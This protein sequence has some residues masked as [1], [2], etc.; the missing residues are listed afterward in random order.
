M[1]R[2]LFISFT[3]HLVI[4]LVI[5]FLSIR[6]KSNQ[7]TRPAVIT[8]QILKGGT[9]EP[10]T[11]KPA[12]HLVEPAPKPTPGKKD[13]ERPKPKSSSKRD[14]GIVQRQGLGAKIEGIQVLGYNYYLQEMLERI[15]ENW[16]NLY[17]SG[18][19]RLKA[20]VVF[21]IERDG[22]LVDIKLEK[23]SGNE[24]FDESCVRAVTVTRKLP[25][26]PNEFTAP[27]IKIHL[28]FER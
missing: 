10:E 13:A 17:H 18:S 2:E 20:T 8:V 6:Q 27:R 4:F 12:P 25:P 15:G 14:D 7:I 16:E 3:G 19:Q 24:M 5:S 1:K 26:L 11:P 28:E 9:Q 21:V 22:R 23:G